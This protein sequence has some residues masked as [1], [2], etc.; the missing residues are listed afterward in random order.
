MRG[1]VITKGIA[2][3]EGIAIPKPGRARRPDF[4]VVGAGLFGS[5]FAR[6]A[7]DRGLHCLVIER[8]PHVGGNVYTYEHSPKRPIVVH[9]YGAHIFKT[10]SERVWKYVLRFADFN[11]Y[12]NQVLARFGDS[13]YNLPFNMN[14]FH[15]LWGVITPAEAEEVIARQTAPYRAAE[16]RNLEL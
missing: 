14:T 8:R 5:V 10:N 1:I 15:Q 3:P 6:E 2:I 4:L 7:T 16:P 13:L 12:T 9:K 11:R